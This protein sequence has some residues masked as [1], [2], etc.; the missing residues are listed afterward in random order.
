MILTE[1]FYVFII[2]NNKIF[3]CKIC[4]AVDTLAEELIFSVNC[5][6]KHKF[7]SQNLNISTPLIKGELHVSQH[8]DLNKSLSFGDSLDILL[9]ILFQCICEKCYFGTLMFSNMEM[10]HH[11]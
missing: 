5:D 8:L 3:V 4:R 10:G 2:S 1:T 6:L 9:A 7:S 11:F